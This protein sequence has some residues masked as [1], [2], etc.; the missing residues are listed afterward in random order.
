M[1]VPIEF[2][3]V[4]VPK[5]V[6]EEKYV[7][8]LQ[9]YKADCPNNSFLADTHI[10]RVGFMSDTELHEYCEGLIRK[11]LHFNDV[12]NSSTDFVVV[13][14]LIGFQWAVDW[15]EKDDEGFVSYTMLQ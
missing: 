2:F 10:T 4:V 13:Q 6:L 14:N 1:S 15:L 5:L 3:S 7:D 11:G 9:G 12:V 8:G